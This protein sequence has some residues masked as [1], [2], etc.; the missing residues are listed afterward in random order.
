[1]PFGVYSRTLR[2]IRDPVERVT[3]LAP[4]SPPLWLSI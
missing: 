3:P 1:M 2:T 4:P